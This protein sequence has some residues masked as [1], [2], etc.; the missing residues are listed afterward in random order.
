MTNVSRRRRNRTVKPYRGQ[1]YNMVIR[2]FAEVPFK[3]ANGRFVKDSKGNNKKTRRV[4]ICDAFEIYY[5]LCLLDE[6][7]KNLYER[8]LCSKGDSTSTM[9]SDFARSWKYILR[10]YATKAPRGARQVCIK[11]EARLERVD[12]LIND[13]LKEIKEGK[14]TFSEAL[15][16]LRKEVGGQYYR[17]TVEWYADFIKQAFAMLGMNVVSEYKNNPRFGIKYFSFSEGDS[18][19]SLIA[20]SSKML[21]KE[22][23]RVEKLKELRDAK[24]KASLL[25][26]NLIV[27]SSPVY[28]DDEDSGVKGKAIITIAYD[29]SIAKFPKP[30]S[31]PNPPKF[32]KAQYNLIV[33]LESLVK[34]HNVYLGNIDPREF[35]ELPKYDVVREGAESV[36]ILKDEEKVERIISQIIES[37]ARAE[38]FAVPEFKPGFGVLPNGEPE[39]GYHRGGALKGKPFFKYVIPK[40]WLDKY[41]QASRIFDKL[42]SF[43]KHH[44]RVDSYYQAL[45]RYKQDIKPFVQGVYHSDFTDDTGIQYQRF[46]E[47][48]DLAQKV[49][50]KRERAEVVRDL[51]PTISLVSMKVDNYPVWD[52]TQ[53]KIVYK[54]K[55]IKVTEFTYPDGRKYTPEMNKEILNDARA[56]IVQGTLTPYFKEIKDGDGATGISKTLQVAKVIDDSGEEIEMVVQGRYSGLTLS[57][58]M[59]ME[60]KFLEEGYFTRSQEGVAIKNRIDIDAEGN[61]STVI[62]TYDEKKKKWINDQRLI[63]PYI[64]LNPTTKKLVLGIPGGQ[65]NTADRNLMSKLAVK[66]SSIKKHL[67]PSLEGA[68]KFNPFYTFAPED[69]EI[70]RDTLGSVALSASASKFMDE[71]YATL[72]AKETATTEESIERFTP[73]ALG[74]FVSKTKGKEFNFNNKQREAASWLEA[75]EMRGVVA[76]DTGVG[77]TLTSLVA[78]KSSINKELEEGGAER[79]FLYV[80]PTNLVGN[81]KHSVRKFMVE[82]GKFE[83]S[84]GV[85]EEMPNWKE[86]VLNRI[87][88]LSYE[89]FVKQFSN[90]MGTEQKI[91]DEDSDLKA[92]ADRV[93]RSIRF[94]GK[95]AVVTYDVCYDHDQNKEL[96][97]NQVSVKAGVLTPEGVVRKASKLEGVQIQR[98][99]VQEDY[100]SLSASEEKSAK[101]ERRELRANLKKLTAKVEAKAFPE[102]NKYF[103]GKYYACFFDEINEIFGSKK[104]DREKN[105]A[106]SSL[107]HP[108]KVFLTASALDRDPVDLYRLSTLAK[109]QVPTAKSEKA[110]AQKYGNVLAGRMVAL[111]PNKEVREQFYNW[112]KENAYFSPKMDISQDE[113]GVNY[114]DVNLPVLQPLKTRTIT[115]RMPRAVESEYRKEAKAITKHLELML[116]KYRDLRSNLDNLKEKGDFLE[117]KDKPYQ[118]LTRATGKIASALNKL[119]KI[120]AGLFKVKPATSVFKENKS[121]RIIYFCSNENK[122]L[123]EAVVAKNSLIRPDKVHAIC[124]TS[125]IHFYRNGKVIARATSKSNLSVEEFDSKY[126]QK[127]MWSK[128]GKASE[129]EAEESATWAMDISKKYVKENASLATVVCND[130]YARGFNFQTFTKVVHL[131]RG[132]GFDSE[133]LKQR[134]ARAYRGGQSDQVEEVYID[135]TF[136]PSSEF[137]GSVSEDAITQEGVLKDAVGISRPELKDGIQYTTWMWD[138][139]DWTK[140]EDWTFDRQ[141]SSMNP[142]INELFTDMGYVK[143]IHVDEVCHERIVLP[144]GT[145]P[146]DASRV[147]REYSAVSLDQIKSIVNQADQEFFQDIIVNGLKS[148]LTRRL[149]QRISDAG[150]AVVTP[151]ALIRSMVNPTAENISRL[152]EELKEFD[153][154][155]ISHVRLDSSRYDNVSEWVNPGN[156]RTEF[157][158]LSELP[159]G[160]YGIAQLNG[161][162]QTLFDLVGG[163]NLDYDLSNSEGKIQCYNRSPLQQVF[164]SNTKFIE[165]LERHIDPYSEEITNKLFYMKECAPQG[166]GSK[167]LFSEIVTALRANMKAINTYASKSGGDVGYFVWPKFGFDAEIELDELFYDVPDDSPDQTLVSAVRQIFEGQN[168]VSI[169]DL[170]SVTA[171]LKVEGEDTSETTP[172]G[173]ILW[174]RYGYSIEVKL[175]LT[176]GSKSMQIANAYMKK[177]AMESNLTVEDFLNSPPD[178]FDVNNPSC[179]VENI[180]MCIV[181]GVLL[182]WEDVVR[183]Y[184]E[185]FKS[186]WYSDYAVVEKVRSL[187]DSESRFN[188]FVKKMGLAVAPSAQDRSPSNRLAST[189]KIDGS[190]KKLLEE[191]NDPCLLAVWEEIRLK[192]YAGQIVVGLMESEDDPDII[193]IQ[194]ARKAGSK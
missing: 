99:Q 85:I 77:K 45:A 1:L 42:L 116:V 98:I 112:V 193:E 184:P 170:L 23:E 27:E 185:A 48:K 36:L 39:A 190:N 176:E 87:D 7:F 157:S 70:I 143:P 141:T 30:G 129:E 104:A 168:M 164:V 26:Q 8:S 138:E 130:K 41:L 66:I 43:Q 163:V 156:F 54:T 5:D 91:L 186:A 174:E 28:V 51:E 159:N 56:R 76:L 75:S 71:Y 83:R 97:R 4:E 139:D 3:D 151:M 22:L 25:D 63:E 125:F 79:R 111:K 153:S 137:E 140:I 62:R 89:D 74:G 31:K 179:W 32:T 147:P 122:N 113:M 110:F 158:K 118:D 132:V 84:D 81:L 173:E 146:K 128:F 10:M 11:L 15:N 58:I 35:F 124:W 182:G 150:E 175:D 120:S 152:N 192:N 115:T 103:E 191:A 96:W 171:D 68:A 144:K 19:S 148:D 16:V 49:I 80:S 60:G 21:A 180:N 166:Y 59:N 127:N 101:K 102:V 134:T 109:G 194:N 117:K 114:T 181:E 172:V 40:R 162:E 178:L 72:R 136:T 107:T 145:E 131:D 169:I 94:K 69:F 14:K 82:G 34:E 6:F 17:R 93:H 106:V 108:R 65:T 57:T 167:I 119:S 126:E 18:M 2:N 33:N 188:A 50:Q 161:V 46:D 29:P 44:E 154:N 13:S 165:T 64:T 52:S 12:S 88:E 142:L 20:N 95:S 67:D 149:D 61:V 133:I 123:A 38:K 100:P 86:I 78:I 135:A 177:K 9:Q 155:P 24:L 53:D 187:C 55:S 92:E 105:T 90:S 160:E 189:S 37:K 183:Q 121:S 47:V 73:E